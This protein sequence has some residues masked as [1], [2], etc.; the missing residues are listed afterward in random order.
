M[1]NETMGE[2]YS[3]HKPRILKIQSALHVKTLIEFW[4]C[5]YEKQILDDNDFAYFVQN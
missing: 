3:K 5:N 1:K 4:E 2:L